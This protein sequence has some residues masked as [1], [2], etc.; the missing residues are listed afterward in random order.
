MV[1][2]KHVAEVGANAAIVYARITWRAERTGRWVATHQQIAEETG[3]APR[4]VKTATALLRERGWI[5]AE[6]GG[7]YDRTSAWVLI[8]AGQAQGTESVSCKVQNPSLPRDQIAHFEGTESVISSLETVETTT[9][10]PIPPVLSVVP[11]TDAEFDA[12]WEHY[13]RKVGKKA[14]RAAFTKARRTTP[15]EPIARGLLAQLPGMRA[16]ELRYVKHPASWL[17]GEAWGDVPEHAAPAE[18]GRDVFGSPETVAGAVEL[19]EG[20]QRPALGARR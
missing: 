16:T 17:N 5:A 18:R 7:G 1:H 20:W 14:A 19:L 2:P 9:D 8:T 11:D 4:A 3:L 10:P 13:P 12:F 6:Q 15:L